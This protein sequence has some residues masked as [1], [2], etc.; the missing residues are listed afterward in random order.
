VNR[1][2]EKALVRFGIQPGMVVR[3]RHDGVRRLGVVDRITRRAT[4]LAQDGQGEQYSDGRR[5]RKFYV[6][7]QMLEAAD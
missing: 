5:Y 3:F 1:P 2:K 4:V 7:V 6:P